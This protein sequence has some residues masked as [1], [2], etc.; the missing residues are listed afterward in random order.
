MKAVKLA[1]SVLL[2][3]ITLFFCILLA[4][5]VLRSNLKYQ[6]FLLDFFGRVKLSCT[7]TLPDALKN[8]KEWGL[9]RRGGLPYIYLEGNLESAV[10]LPFLVICHGA[11][12]D[13]EDC[14]SEYKYIS[15]QFQINVI[16][17][18]YPGFGKRRSLDVSENQKPTEANLFYQYPLELD[19]L[20][21]Q[22]GLNWSNAILV[23]QCLGAAVTLS[24]A[25]R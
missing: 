8:P 10:D 21:Q 11:A 18:E 15:H 3:T 19:D 2:L 4:M 12:S 9:T 14:Y 22:L 24:I 17:L 6:N 25:S 7:E 16:C 20:I 23:G 5:Y 1:A 13:L